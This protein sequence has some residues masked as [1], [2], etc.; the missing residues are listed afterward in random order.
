MILSRR[1][2]LLGLGLLFLLCDGEVR[3]QTEDLPDLPVELFENTT[4]LGQ[5]VSE[6]LER[7]E[8]IPL[9]QVQ[10]A[11]D[12]AAPNDGVY[13]VEFKPERLIKIKA[14]PFMISTVILP[15]WEEI[16]D[17]LMGDD[18]L[19]LA[20][21]KASHI[22]SILARKEECDTTMTL[23]GASG[24]VYGFYIRSEPILS[25]HIPDV[26]VHVKASEPLSLVKKKEGSYPSK[27]KVSFSKA[28]KKSS[29]SD[30]LE[31]LHPNLDE[32]SFAFEMSAKDQ[33][34]MSI[35]PLHVYSDGLWIW[36]DYG[37]K[38]DSVTLP[39]VY[40]KVDGVDTPVNTRVVGTKIVVQGFGPLSLK[41]GKK[42]VCIEPMEAS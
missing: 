33:A 40:K 16:Q 11:W 7:P 12:K 24:Y 9:G 3:A 19:F 27:H 39:A 35:A 38:W 5:D 2:H 22:V 25:I 30:Y 13:V 42:V 37:K 15:E 6:K 41:S 17:I 32:I 20:E 14:R 36:L 34:S 1:Y 23:I 28:E 31:T 18:H 10:G 26:V 8:S 29:E 4:L 21:K